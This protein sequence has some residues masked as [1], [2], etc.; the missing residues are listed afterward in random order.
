MNFYNDQ[1]ELLYIV[2]AQ[3]NL[4]IFINIASTKSFVNPDI[5][6]M[7]F[8]CNTRE[9]SFQF[10]TAYGTCAE[11]FSTTILCSE[12]IGFSCWAFADNNKFRRNKMTLNKIEYFG[13]PNGDN[14]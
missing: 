1:S 14:P 7:Y 6:N 5:A 9:G 8:N 12:V 4:K 11:G 3:Y 10:S 2:S 13:Q